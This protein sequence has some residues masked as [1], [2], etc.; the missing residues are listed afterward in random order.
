MAV[1]IHAVIAPQTAMKNHPRNW[2]M[3]SHS[4]QAERDRMPIQA[5]LEAE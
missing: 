5:N 3:T 2:N 1:N 4:L